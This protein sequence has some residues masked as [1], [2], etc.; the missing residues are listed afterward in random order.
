MNSSKKEEQNKYFLLNKKT[1]TNKSSISLKKISK[2]KSIHIIKDNNW[3]NGFKQSMLPENNLSKDNNFHINL[4]IKSF[5]EHKNLIDF[6]NP[7]YDNSLNSLSPVANL[8]NG[9]SL[10][11]TGSAKIRYINYDFNNL[12]YLNMINLNNIYK[13]WDELCVSKSYRNLFCRIYKELNDKDKQEIYSREINELTSIKNDINILKTNIEIRLNTIK[14]LSELNDKLNTEIINNNRNNEL[15]I[16]EISKKIEILRDQTINVCIS[17]KKVK[18]KINGIKHLDKFDIDIIS[19]KFNFDKNYIIKMKAELNFLKEGYV[20]F[21]FNINNDQTP[22]L[23][24]ASEKNEINN[25]KSL[26]NIVPLDEEKKCDIL[27]CIYYIYQEL[28]AYQNEKV[29]Q[30]ILRRISPLKKTE[31]NENKILRLTNGKEENNNINN[32]NETNNLILRKSSSMNN[33]IIKENYNDKK[34]NILNIKQKNFIYNKKKFMNINKNG[35]NLLLNQFRKQINTNKENNNITI[36]LKYNN[37]FI[38]QNKKKNEIIKKEKSFSN[39][40]SEKNKN[41]NFFSEDD[42]INE[43]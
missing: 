6:Q 12:K 25:I 43:N 13:L 27:E 11:K 26:Y 18:Y 15:I 3:S 2:V 14:E 7:K 8:N 20:K 23:L 5:S 24:N 21:Y 30:N 34:N 31:A 28:I 9:K 22:F 41:I 40:D 32:L 4:S 37:Q 19:E 38:I 42:K 39:N 16:N 29:N 1:P 33:L 10:I 35:N 36:G 17:M